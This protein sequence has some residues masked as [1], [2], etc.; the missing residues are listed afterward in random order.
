MFKK[1]SR[2]SVWIKIIW[3]KLAILAGAGALLL[4]DSLSVQSSVSNFLGKIN[5]S[6]AEGT[7]SLTGGPDIWK[8]KD[9]LAINRRFEALDTAFPKDVVK[10]IAWCES[11]WSQM[12]ENGNPFVT[13]NYRWNGSRRLK[14]SHDWGIM[15]I[16]EK[17]ESLDDGSWD[18]ERIKM[19]PEYNLRA[20]V[21]ILEN[22]RHYVR[23]LRRQK[24][25]RQ[26]EARYHLKGHSELEITLKAYNGFQPSWS[27]LYRI[28]AAMSEKPWEKA[29]WIQL[30]GQGGKPAQASIAYLGEDPGR[31]F[32]AW[33]HPLVAGPVVWAQGSRDFFYQINQP[34]G[35]E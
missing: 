23:F 13:A 20:G 8:A 30:L 33:G 28:Q 1:F 21:A 18:L 10:A 32:A 16:N 9:Y 31:R 6:F 27:Y 19:D 26:L 11:E 17:M 15:Q 2:S 24:Y 29:M 35:S 4:G 5:S 22:K 14:T 3:V 34:D 7:S 25:W 12:D